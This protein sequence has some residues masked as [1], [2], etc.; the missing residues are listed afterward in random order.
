MGRKDPGNW[1]SKESD[2]EG[3]R[4][5]EKDRPA[6]GDPEKVRNPISGCWEVKRGGQV[7]AEDAGV[8]RRKAG[9]PPRNVWSRGW[10]WGRDVKSRQ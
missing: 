5:P 2:R 9:E 1:G 4:E 7:G 8:R 6:E 3:K 10:V